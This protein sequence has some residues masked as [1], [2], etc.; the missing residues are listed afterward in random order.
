MAQTQGRLTL[1]RT[2]IQVGQRRDRTN[3]KQEKTR[4]RE[5]LDRNLKTLFFHP[6][7]LFDKK[8]HT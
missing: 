5:T 2:Q 7:L 3:P 8:N 1:D 4:H 6:I